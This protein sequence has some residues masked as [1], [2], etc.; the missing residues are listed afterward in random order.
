M[1]MMMS[2]TKIYI[3]SRYSPSFGQLFAFSILSLHKSGLWQ[4]FQSGFSIISL[5]NGSRTA[6]SYIQDQNQALNGFIR[7]K[8]SF[9][10]TIVL[11]I[12]KTRKSAEISCSGLLCFVMAILEDR[13][14]LQDGFFYC[15]HGR[16][17]Q[18][19]ICDIEESGRQASLA[20]VHHW[21]NF[22]FKVKNFHSQ[23]IAVSTQFCEHEKQRRLINDLAKNRPASQES[24]RA[25]SL[26]S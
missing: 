10:L 3:F 21:N 19:R 16:Y 12:G 2:A 25:G 14:G 23:E 9:Y 26:T 11:I 22:F 15:I 5:A 17:R 20:A 6:R 18:N 1:L 24:N 7:V 4:S 13:K 8:T